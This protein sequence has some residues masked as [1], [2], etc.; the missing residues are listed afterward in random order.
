MIDKSLAVFENY[1][2]RR[3]YDED[4]ETWYFSVVDIIQALIQQPDY[5]AARNY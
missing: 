3:I 5:Q 2:I 1:N 4:S